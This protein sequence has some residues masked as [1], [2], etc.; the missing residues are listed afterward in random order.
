M[1]TKEHSKAYIGIIGLGAFLCILSYTIGTKEKPFQPE[2]VFIDTC[3]CNRDSLT[4]ENVLYE[5]ERQGITHP[6]I[7]LKQ[8]CLETGF[9]TSRVCREEN[10][11]FGFMDKNGYFCFKTWQESVAYYKNWQDRKYKGGDYYNFLDN[12]PYAEDGTYTNKLKQIKIE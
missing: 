8:V 7:V 5:I 3:F 9:L 11:L 4:I 10:N 1:T 2:K 6:E 12:L